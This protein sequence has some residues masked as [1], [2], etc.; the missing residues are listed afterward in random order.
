MVG[1][2]FLPPSTEV[3]PQEASRR[4]G[5]LEEG[6]KVVALNGVVEGIVVLITGS[7]EIHAERQGRENEK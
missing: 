7:G 5:E 1:S 2:F 6:L 4:L 3:T